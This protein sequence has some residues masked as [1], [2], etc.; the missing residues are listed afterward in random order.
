VRGRRWIGLAAGAFVVA[1]SAAASAAW[2]LPALAWWLDIGG[3][4]PRADIVFALAGDDERR[5]F[6][7]AALVKAGLAQRVV[8]VET[9]HSADVTDGIFPP[10]H[11]IAGKIFQSRG[12][13]PDQVLL[14]P[15]NSTSTADEVD[16][17][18]Q[19]LEDHPDQ[20]ACVVTNAYHTRRTRWTLRTRL[21]D[22]FDRVSVFSAPNP[23]FDGD[24]WWKT[25]AAMEAVISEYLKLGWYSLRYGHGVTALAV[26]L[27]IGIM[28]PRCYRTMVRFLHRRS[29]STE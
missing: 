8:V 9:E 10:S 11:V 25:P 1:V 16:R 18:K 3:G 14:L 17:L 23:E 7:A 26:G 29:R 27:A 19:Y 2:W 28:S 15:G 21:G 6:V 24:S 22:H 20:R 4:I 12:L 5:P 13:R